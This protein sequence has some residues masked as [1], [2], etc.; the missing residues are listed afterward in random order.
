MQRIKFLL[1][2]LVLGTVPVLLF[3]SPQPVQA[4]A[5]YYL[6]PAVITDTLGFTYNETGTVIDVAGNLVSVSGTCQHTWPSWDSCG[7]YVALQRAGLDVAGLVYD[8]QLKT[9]ARPAVNAL[10]T[11]G[12]AIGTASILD[13]HI[14]EEIAN[15]TVPPTE[16]W[17]ATE[18]PTL[19]LDD[20]DCDLIFD[21]EWDDDATGSTSN[22]NATSVSGQGDTNHYPFAI[23]VNFWWI[24]VGCPVGWSPAGI[25]CV[26]DDEPEPPPIYLPYDPATNCNFNYT[27]TI[28]TTEGTTGTAH[29]SYTVPANLILNYSFEDADASGLS[30]AWW[31]FNSD[32]PPIVNDWWGNSPLV[33]HL[34]N[35][36]LASY[37]Q[38][39]QYEL[40][41]DLP[42][43]AAGRYMAGIYIKPYSGYWQHAI[44]AVT[45]RW[46]GSPVVTGYAITNTW[47][48]MTGTRIAGTGSSWL[49]IDYYTLVPGSLADIYA[50]DVFIFPVPETG[51][52]ILCEPE[53]YPVPEPITTTLPTGGGGCAVT[54][55]GLCFPAVL[56]ASC[57]DCQRPASILQFGDWILWLFCGLR[58]LFFCHL[59]N[60]ILVFMNWL[61]GVWEHVVVFFRYLPKQIVAT[62]AWAR[63]TV[64]NAGDFI[65]G[66]WN[67][68]VSDGLNFFRA[69]LL[70]L[71]NSS[72]VQSIWNFVSGVDYLWQTAQALVGLFVEMVRNVFRGL[73]DF[74]ELLI[75][76]E[77]SVRDA[78]AGTESYDLTEFFPGGTGLRSGEFSRE[79]LAELDGPDEEKAL[80]LFLLALGWFDATLPALGLEYAQWAIFG[81]VGIVVVMWTL[82]EWKQIIP[83]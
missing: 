21:D 42:L 65:V 83:N 79:S 70:N 54:Y 73:V 32:V 44:S 36:Y 7:V 51:D 48:V 11:T 66:M 27:A 77:T 68:F 30:P 67:E 33:A 55:G 52:S 60:W 41:Q 38:S 24:V 6:F 49:E 76:M 47:N 50:D 10:N 2:S 82:N 8:W 81:V 13:L 34:G 80:Y 17:C 63:T 3:L 57:W 12:V 45:M 40:I 19:D 26:E 62:A 56:D 71:L 28:T 59:Y 5:T 9:T 4:Q 75:A 14:S 18:I 74:M 78:I 37:Q 23:T 72:I 22:R 64:I 31:T 69:L 15:G 43:Y 1:L 25:Y 61:S 39:N 16:R 20:L 35:R 46:N 29:Y 53:Y 58:N